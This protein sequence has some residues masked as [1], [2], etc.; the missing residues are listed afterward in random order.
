MADKYTPQEL[1]KIKAELREV[2][3]LTNQF[4]SEWK[5][6][7]GLTES[8][9]LNMGK[10]VD[11]SKKVS[12]AAKEEKTFREEVQDLTKEVLKNVEK[13]TTEEFKT[14]DVSKKLVKSRRINDK[15]LVK[16]LGHLRNISNEQERQ[17]KLLNEQANLI[18]KPLQALDSM[19][20]QIPII[21][22]LLS[23]SLGLDDM[24]GDLMSSF[25]AVTAQKFMGKQE[26]NVAT[27][28]D[29][30]IVNV[31]PNRVEDVPI[32]PQKVDVAA[33]VEDTPF[34]VIPNT[35]EDGEV[36]ID[37]QTFAASVEDTSFNAIPNTV[38]N[39][40]FA[41]QNLDISATVSDDV[42]VPINQRAVEKSITD[43]MNK[44][45][46]VGGESVASSLYMNSYQGMV[47]GGTSGAIEAASNL[48]TSNPFMKGGIFSWV[49][50]VKDFF[51][52]PKVKP[53]D[54]LQPQEQAFEAISADLLKVKNIETEQKPTADVGKENIGEK[55]SQPIGFGRELDPDTVNPTTDIA[56]ESID[57]EQEIKINPDTENIEK[58]LD[59]AGNDIT[60]ELKEASEGF[61]T[62]QAGE[63]WKVDPSVQEA[64]QKKLGISTEILN[65]E[66]K[67]TV[68]ASENTKEAGS[69][70]SRL[71]AGPVI[72]GAIAA[73]LFL[74][75]NRLKGVSD[76]LGT[77][78]GQMASFASLI[79]PD[80]VTAFAKEFGTVENLT[81]GS[82]GNL[83]LMELRFNTSAETAAK[84]A[85][86]MGN[87]SSQSTSAMIKDM[88]KFQE[89]LREAGVVAPKQV[90]EDIAANTELFAKFGKD[91]GKNI[92]DAAVAA[93]KLGIS[94]SDVAGTAES[95]L[96]FESSIEKQMQ[97]EIL[98]GRGLNLDYA[99]RLAF[100]GDF[101][102]LQKE[103]VRLVGSEAEWNELNY[104]QR[105]AMA[106]ALGLNVEKVASI[107]GAQERLNQTSGVMERTWADIS[108]GFIAMAPVI[109]GIVG[110]LIAALPAIRTAMSGGLSLTADT[111]SV[112]KGI[113]VLSAGVG[114]G[115]VA[116][117][118]LQNVT[119]VEQSPGFKDLE[120]GK[121][122]DIQRGEARAHAG[123]TITHTDELGKLN[124][125]AEAWR[126]FKLQQPP[127]P[128]T[129]KMEDLLGEVVT[130]NKGILAE[131]KKVVVEN[132][133]LREQNLFLFGKLGRT[134]EGQKLA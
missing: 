23:A 40:P 57:A 124:E 100:A 63:Q 54:E 3:S 9:A 69:F 121:K 13:I 125:D 32:D 28:V 70:I 48:K 77:G 44:A 115:T 16:Q 104:V 112:A 24:A 64:A 120:E 106:D 34:N 86:A 118:G 52:E 49:G 18:G 6:V 35:V 94:L 114:L 78:I 108:A 68:A 122:V 5:D 31:I 95:L 61:F 2:R 98:L 97:A 80:A 41:P 75:F 39:V 60:N 42:N 10:I 53:G 71:K 83:K 133:I 92:M 45:S 93:A 11:L 7:M 72:G 37:N 25:K 33:V 105:T 117:I 12:T 51:I 46:I 131:N 21:G 65:V 111:L 47:E 90:M 126:G 17:H 15:E 14:F 4:S 107:I 8:T 132:K 129:S 27:V 130:S 109:L 123:E 110:G 119:S 99:R 38:E 67:S 134:I 85:K 81:A 20:K 36:P 127:P 103:L 1:N 82:A 79:N 89:Q 87:I 128:D 43:G 102:D 73:S 116:G 113:G 19:I 55:K 56:A 74:V 29:D 76:E 84:L 66:K 96:D 58:F 22:D 101:E 26:V 62:S 59:V 50:K 91:G 30:A 88:I